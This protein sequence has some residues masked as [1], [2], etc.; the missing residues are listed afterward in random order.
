MS[1]KTL[2]L[3]SSGLKNIVPNAR[4]EEE[5][6][7]IFL[8]QTIRMKTVFA[9][10][11]SPKVSKL[12]IL[13]PTIDY[14]SLTYQN[15][16]ITL[17]ES[18][19]SKFKLISCGYSVDINEEESNQMKAISILLENNELFSKLNEL[20]SSEINEEN[21]DQYI[22]NLTIF[23]SISPSFD[24]FNYS[25][26]ID[27]ISSHFYSID[28]N[29]LKRLPKT[30]IYSIISNPNLQLDT[31][32]SLFEFIDELFE[33]KDDQYLI[34]FYEKVEFSQLSE[35]KF[36]QFAEVFNPSDM[37]KG[38]WAKLRMCFH[39][40]K[41]TGIK[42]ERYKKKNER[43]KGN[44][45]IFEYDG[46]SSNAFRGIIDHLT[47]ESGGNVSENGTVN[48]TSTGNDG[49]SYSEKNIVDLHNS[50][51]YYQSNEVSN[52]WLKYDFIGRKINLTH[53]SI[54]NRHDYD[55]NH[56]RNWVIEGSNN[57]NEWTI[58]DTH[59][60]DETM[61]G[62]NGVH[63][64]EIKKHEEYYRYLR[65]R[66]TGKDSGNCFQYAISALEY[67]GSMIENDQD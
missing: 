16:D 37:T 26:I 30:V 25:A 67:F 34:M 21:I 9:D 38:L 50:Q 61:K 46:N 53:Y 62:R 18:I 3:S 40:S 11:I 59:Q 6:S 8:G 1:T 28:K 63:T 41:D 17:T 27:L 45:K 51:N 24:C 58:L 56:V 60:N 15:K 39:P 19:L 52:A 29:K 36:E 57:N 23:S 22:N 35:T 32:D 7:F 20:F 10:F 12:H 49:F 65:L 42:N 55:A 64:F 31:E 5:F 54:R 43:N 13:D 44:R 14:L 47:K 33:N 66:Q 48:I 4:M 2:I